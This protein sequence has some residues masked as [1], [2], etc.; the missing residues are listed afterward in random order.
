MLLRPLRPLRLAALRLA[1]LRLAALP[2]PHL[3][4]EEEEWAK[5][6]GG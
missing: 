3:R 2:R 4:E 5:T 1:V 6:S